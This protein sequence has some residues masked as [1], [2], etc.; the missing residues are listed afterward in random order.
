MSDEVDF[1]KVVGKVGVS[2]NTIKY[3]SSELPKQF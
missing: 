3:I 1:G 2:L